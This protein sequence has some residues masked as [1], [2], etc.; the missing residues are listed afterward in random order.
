LSARAPSRL[1]DLLFVYEV[2]DGVVGSLEFSDIG[3]QDGRRPFPDGDGDLA[4]Q[5]VLLIECG[6]Q[7][8]T[9]DPGIEVSRDWMVPS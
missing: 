2:A 5:S 1:L 8:G 6:L 4:E 9:F 3:A 7:A